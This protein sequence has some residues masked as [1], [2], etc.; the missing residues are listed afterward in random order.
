MKTKLQVI[1]GDI[2]TV[3]VDAI[4]N[5]ANQSLLGGGGVDG[6]I[7]Y[8]AGPE[9]LQECRRLNGCAT[10]DAKITSGYKLPSRYV[11][12]TVGPIWKNGRYNEAELLA[13]CYRNSL[14]LARQKGIKS[15]AF[16]SISTGAYNYPLKEA[17]QIAVST[18]F[19]F[20]REYPDAFDLIEWVAFGE[21]TYIEYRESLRNIVE[22][23]EKYS[24]IYDK[25]KG[26]VFAG[27]LGD[28]LG[29]PVEFL[30]YEE[31]EEQYGKNG[32][33]E[34]ELTGDRAV[35]SDDTQMT[36]FTIEGMLKG[37]NR[38]IMKGIGADVENY[39]YLS[40]LRWAQTQNMIL[41]FEVPLDWSS[42]LADIPEMNQWRAPGNTCLTALSSGRMGTIEAPVNN[43]KG[44]GGVMRT[45][46]LGFKK[47][48]GNP[49]KN[50]AN[51]AAI[52]HGHPL[53]W[54]PAGMLSDI[55][56]KIIYG[57]EQPLKTI[58]K[59]SLNDTREMFRTF[60]EV[61]Y[62]TELINRAIEL[63]E[64]AVDD[65]EVIES[66]GGGWVGEEALAIAVY[67]CLKY[68]TD[69]KKMLTVAVNHS[70]DS[71]STG[72]IAGN[73]LGTYLG[74]SG[75]PK[76]WLKSLEL[77]DVMQKQIEVMMAAIKGEW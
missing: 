71:D 72:A 51:V 28:A 53:G 69:M 18:V 27:A 58:I 21:K 20:V 1:K 26:C 22:K 32:I 33:Q 25:I 23:E 4:V 57:K 7:H 31:I 29:Y 49:L 61:E 8:A 34:L 42:E 63:S 77:T 14:K 40:Y 54:L 36:L 44:C 56:Y 10:G 48:W 39:V 73:I 5:A 3:S 59:E 75:I 11:I 35:F 24:T 64:K 74:M 15:I 65:I 60:K 17:S 45:A 62:L 38:V 55:V 70:G 12:H 66:L 2:T 67:C 13:S 9:L 19:E 6:A 52:T 43:S 76:D 50:G 46:P 41:H 37:Y 16:P 47:E 30:S 68:Q